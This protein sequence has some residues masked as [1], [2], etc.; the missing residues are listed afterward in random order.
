MA[1]RLSPWWVWLVLA[2][3]MALA[4]GADQAAAQKPAAKEPPAASLDGLWRG[5][6]VNGKGE[7]PDAGQTHLEL[8]IKGNQIA[9]QRLDGNRG[10]LG[11]GI[12]KTGPGKPPWMDAAELRTGGK[13]KTYQGICEVT[14]EVF[15]WCV[16]TPGN[17]RP[18]QFET[19][20]Q[21]FLLILKRQ[22]P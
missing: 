16:A 13:P 21:Q 3:V 18:T 10:P 15:K 1:A 12:Y 14:P 9:A 5:W 22:K 17:R 20:G 6:V 11:R 8:L 19:K 2:S 4:L 7:N